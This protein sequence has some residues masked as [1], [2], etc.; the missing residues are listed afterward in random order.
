MIKLRAMGLGDVGQVIALL[1]AFRDEV[2]RYRLF[3]TLRHLFAPLQALSMALPPT[4]QFTPA[5]FTAASNGRVLA[6]L[7]LSKDPDWTTRWKIDQLLLA[8]DVSTYDVASQLAHYALNRYGAEGVQTFIALTHPRYEQALA[9]L[10]ACGFRPLAQ[11]WTYHHA[12]PGQCER[13]AIFIAGLREAT[14]ADA[15]GLKTLSDQTLPVEKRLYMERSARAFSRSFAHATL[16]TLRGRFFKRWVVA[17][18]ARDLL[19]GSVSVASADLQTY[20]ISWMVSSGWPEGDAELLEF[21]LHHVSEQT[22]K[23]T[24]RVTAYSFQKERLA[25]LQAKGFERGEETQL[26]VRDFWTPLQDK[27]RRGASPI[28][29]FSRKTSTA[30]GSPLSDATQQ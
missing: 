28:L 12:S 17:D 8:P 20:D 3:L 15:K 25:M 4:W 1:G 29:L 19:L 27:P 10:K 11:Q 23:A 16:D 13:P 5:I 24:V 26:L 21:A 18:A 14:C 9:L 30:C 2:P 7:G 6:V 22:R